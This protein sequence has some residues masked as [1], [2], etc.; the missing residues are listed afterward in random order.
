MGS[1][2]VSIALLVGS[3]SSFAVEFDAESATSEE[4]V[5]HLQSVDTE[6]E[7]QMDAEEQAQD[8]LNQQGLGTIWDSGRS[9][10]IQIGVASFD[11]EDPSY[12]NTFM[13]KRSLKTMEA[14]LDAKAKIIEFIDT[15][16]T[17]FDKVTTPG[18]DLHAQFK[19]EIESLE[20]KMDAQ[21]QRVAKFLSEVDRTEAEHLQG[22]DFGDRMNSMMDAAISKLDER[23]SVEG[24]EQKKKE[25]FVKAK[26]RF[27][28][29]K[30]EFDALQQKLEATA[31]SIKNESSSEVATV[32]KQPLFGAT[33]VA[34]FES[35]N[36]DKERYT[37]ALVVIWGKKMERVARAMIQGEKLQV[38]PGNESLIA[39]VKNNDW[40]T[41]TGGRR[42][43]DNKG[44][45]H[46]VGIAASK[47]GKSSTSRK[48]ARGM[49]EQFAKKE[50]AMAVFAD[51]ESNKT[52]KAMMQERSG[53]ADKDVS[54]AAESFASTLQQKIENRKLRGLQ[55]VFGKFF[56]HPISQQEIYVSIYS[57]SSET[58]M[59]ALMMQERNYLTKMLDVKS[60][61]RMHAQ[62]DAMKESVEAA[63]RDRSAYNK[64]KGETAK[65]MQ[66]RA[67][68]EDAAVQR[69]RSSG[70]D[71][72]QGRSGYSPNNQEQQR[73][74]A[75][76]GARGGSYSGGGQ[77][78]ALDW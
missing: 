52:A 30:Q 41:S 21:R 34:Q 75:G 16:M 29:A 76:G 14:T 56:L 61:Q 44:N 12:D 2:A 20:N 4:V 68:S 45:V 70:R 62:D 40:A 51:V 69:Q 35:W 28:E 9:Q 57:M 77:S 31:G 18:T 42:F 22:A 59:Q 23:Y 71:R 26:N 60:Q 47:A 66:N 58:A 24:I 3:S 19:E 6:P 38:P 78:N 1:V 32:S 8:F 73:Q 65:S 46:F 11:S 7:Y 25:K 64:A 33:T 15:K 55:K 63:K 5:T 54:V 43:R 39:W 37:V 27:E 72:S 53:G 17:A 67:A 49:S 50:V 48:K 13:T 74:Q 10:L 36:E